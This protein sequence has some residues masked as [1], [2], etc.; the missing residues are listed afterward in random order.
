MPKRNAN[1][2]A[3]REAYVTGG[4]DVTLQKVADQF[5]I[6]ANTLGT[7]CA[8]EKWTEARKSYRED[9]AIRARK[10]LAESESEV[11]LRQIRLGRVLQTRGL[12]RIRIASVKELDVEQARHYVRDGSEI[13]RKALGIEER[14]AAHVNL[15][16]TPAEL[17]NLSDEDLNALYERLKAAAG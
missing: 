16:I 15:N 17:E 6:P 5:H 9:I 4:D 13:E 11:R 1:L 7:H 3:A 2:D 10:K 8:N 12:E 14:G